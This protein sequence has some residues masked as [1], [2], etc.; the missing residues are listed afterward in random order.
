MSGDSA[1]ESAETAQDVVEHAKDQ[2]ETY[3]EKSAK[4]DGDK[5]SFFAG[6]QAAY[7][8]IVEE[9]GDD[10]DFQ[11]VLARGSDAT[12]AGYEAKEVSDSE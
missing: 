12:R 8:G 1:E 10:E 6:L 5:G 11:E 9:F 4:Y 7:A 3:A 2:A